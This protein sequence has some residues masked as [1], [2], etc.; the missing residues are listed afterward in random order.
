MLAELRL[1]RATPGNRTRW[2]HF[3]E[4]EFMPYHCE[5]GVGRILGHFLSYRDDQGFAWLQ[6]FDSSRE[7]ERAGPLLWGSERWKRELGPVA[8]SLLEETRVHVL[9]PAPGSRIAE[10]GDVPFPTPEGDGNRVLE[11]RLYRIRPGRRDTFAEFFRSKTVAPQEASGMRVLGQFFDLEDENC[12]V[13]LRGFPDLESRD[14]RKAEFYDGDL[15]LK[16]LE[17]EA[18]G[19]IEDYSNVWLVTPARSSLFQ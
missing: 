8:A 9:T 1:Y 14:I 13:W 12:F 5:V 15:W 18:F 11:I 4:Q 2:L 10:V 19:M 7:R 16:E 6:G 3:F 17:H